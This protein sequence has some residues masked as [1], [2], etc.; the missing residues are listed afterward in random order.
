MNEGIHTQSSAAPYGAAEQQRFAP[1]AI[2]AAKCCSA[3]QCCAAQR[4]TAP[5]CSHYAD[6]VMS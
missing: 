4:R 5:H 1:R 6:H 3:A 2:R